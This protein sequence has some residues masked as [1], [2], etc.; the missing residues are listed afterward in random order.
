MLSCSA[1]YGDVDTEQA[2]TDTIEATS[3]GYWGGRT[4]WRTPTTTSGGTVITRTTSDGEPIQVFVPDP[5]PAVEV[6]AGGQ[7]GIVVN[8]VLLSCAP[9]TFCLSPGEG[10][11]GTC[12]VSPGAPVSEG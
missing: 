7:C 1:D 4:W 11:P 10:L 8:G 3:H 12:Q 9:G 5:A 6:P 2:E